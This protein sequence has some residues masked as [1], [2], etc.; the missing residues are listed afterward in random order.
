MIRKGIK[1]YAGAVRRRYLNAS[2]A[3]KCVILNEFCETTGY[4][5][6]SAIRLLRHSPQT[7]FRPHGVS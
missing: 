2:K 5:G 7:L 6:K 3:Q 4:H 1:E